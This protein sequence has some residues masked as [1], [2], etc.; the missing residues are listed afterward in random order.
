MECNYC[1]TNPEEV[2]AIK[3]MMDNLYRDLKN[4]SMV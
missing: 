3:K 4:R 2:E 1:V